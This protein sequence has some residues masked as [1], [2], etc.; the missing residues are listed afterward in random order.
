MG[1][2]ALLTFRR[3]ASGNASNSSLDISAPKDALDG[4]TGGG[5]T[6]VVPSSDSVVSLS[7][8]LTPHIVGFVVVVVMLVA[9]VVAVVFLLLPLSVFSWL[10]PLRNAHVPV[11]APADSELGR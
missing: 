2:H 9:V 5:T 4:D 7:L 8:S 11:V 3:M 10:L 1:M 6:K